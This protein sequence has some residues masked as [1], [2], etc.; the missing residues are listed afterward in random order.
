[1]AAGDLIQSQTIDATHVLQGGVGSDSRLVLILKSDLASYTTSNIDQVTALTLAANK[2]AF[3]FEGIRQ[4]LVPSAEDVRVD[5]G[6]MQFK[7]Q[8]IFKIFAYDQVSKNNWGRLSQGRYVAILENSKLDGNTIEIYGIDVGLELTAGKRANQ[9]MGGAIVITLTSPDK[10]FEAKPPRTL[11]G[12]TGVYATNR[13][14]VDAL[15][16]L[17][18][19]TSFA[20]STFTSA[21]GGAPVI[22]GTNFFANG[23]NSAVLKVEAINNLTGASVLPASFSSVTNTS[24]TVTFSAAGI[25][26]GNYSLKVTTTKG[27]VKSALNLIV[28]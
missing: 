24:I 28:T 2:S 19:I 4:S 8:V 23:S 16:F 6:Q 25:P 27:F 9:E 12:G 14:I 3:L 13:A 1:M 10:E 26:V 5:S 11:D 20:V 22:T 17:P 21:A 7:H 15:L 18:T